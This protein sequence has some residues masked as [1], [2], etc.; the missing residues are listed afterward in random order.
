MRHGA[1]AADAE[2]GVA[3]TAVAVEAGV[4]GTQLA[5]EAAGAEWEEWGAVVDQPM[6]AGPRCQEEGMAAGGRGWRRGPAAAA[7]PGEWCPRRM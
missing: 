7:A 1:V 3:D 5:A 6:R 2:A 4:E